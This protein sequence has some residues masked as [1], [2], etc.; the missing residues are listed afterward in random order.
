MSIWGLDY[1]YNMHPECRFL[2]TKNKIYHNRKVCPT[3]W[4]LPT[5]SEWAILI[6]YLGSD[7]AG[8][9]MKETGTAHWLSPNI[10]TNESGFTAI[11]GSL[12]PFE[13]GFLYIDILATWWSSSEI[14]SK[15][16]NRLL[17]LYWDKK[18]NETDG[19]KKNGLSVRCVQ[20]L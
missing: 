6:N 14:S 11:P 3:G 18:I 16:A 20:D 4:H 10:A 12:R 2:T 17:L 1:Q 5:K 15:K 7:S 8:S 13:S 9:K 19:G